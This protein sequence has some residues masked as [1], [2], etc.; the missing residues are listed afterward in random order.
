MSAYSAVEPSQVARNSYR[1]SSIFGTPLLDLECIYELPPRKQGT[2]WRPGTMPGS[3][4]HAVRDAAA[5]RGCGRGSQLW[6]Q[7]DALAL[8]LSA[9]ERC[10][11]VLTNRDADSAGRGLRRDRPLFCRSSRSRQQGHGRLP[12]I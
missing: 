8:E 12:P 5:G 4:G 1:E 9:A 11:P 7:A 6:W 10:Y 2:G 3:W